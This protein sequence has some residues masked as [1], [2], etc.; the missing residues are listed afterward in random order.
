[1]RVVVLAAMLALAGCVIPKNTDIF[2]P[3][4]TIEPLT[5]PDGRA[6]F[7]AYCGGYY[8]G[9]SYCYEGARKQCAGN[10]E[11]LRQTEA[12]RGETGTENR[13]IEFVCAS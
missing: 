10:Y 1:M 2:N 9:I 3:A 8:S 5:T 4:A 11:I 13:R 7:I 12:P 6:G